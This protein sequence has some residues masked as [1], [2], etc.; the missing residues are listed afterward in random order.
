ML[1]CLL[2]GKIRKGGKIWTRLEQGCHIS[3]GSTYKNGKIYTK[4]PHNIHTIFPKIIQNG[5]KIL[6]MAK[7]ITRSVQSKA[8]ENIPKL[9]FFVSGNLGLERSLKVRAWLLTQII[10]YTY[11]LARPQMPHHKKNNHGKFLSAAVTRVIR[12]F[13]KKNQPMTTKNRP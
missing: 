8:L 9:G 5:R 4:W 6:E 11:A 12:C 1:I 2:T 10:A 7:K 13:C 3:L